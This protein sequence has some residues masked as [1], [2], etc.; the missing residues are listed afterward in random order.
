MSNLSDKNHWLEIRKS[1]LDLSGSEQIA[2][3]LFHT[4]KGSVIIYTLGETL[5]LE[6]VLVLI[7]KN[8]TNKK[9]T[10]PVTILTKPGMK[11]D[12]R[13]EDYIKIVKKELKIV[14]FNLFNIA[15]P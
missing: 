8:K 11:I 12:P 6:T 2:Q 3:N 7:G 15:K 4:D 14:P 13:C 5:D 10:L 1:V 9:F